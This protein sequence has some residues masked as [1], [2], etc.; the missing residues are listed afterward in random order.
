[1]NNNY[2]L[3]SN[4]KKFIGQGGNSFVSYGGGPLVREEGFRE[5]D[6][7]L[8]IALKGVE[9]SRKYKLPTAW[10]HN[11]VKTELLLGAKLKNSDL[12]KLIMSS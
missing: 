3:P 6:Y 11:R 5:E 9:L 2:K 4:Y 1:V 10:L 8:Q 7:S 12:V